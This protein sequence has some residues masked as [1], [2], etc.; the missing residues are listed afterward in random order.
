MSNSIDS[1]SH[2][3]SLMKL[4]KNYQHIFDV[5]YQLETENE[6]E[7]CNLLKDIKVILLD[8][9]IISPSD[10][11]N[12]ICKIFPYNIRHFKSYWLLFKRFYE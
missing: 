11:V 8:T 7:I 10:M 6:E 5:L 2:Y 3:D 4:F 1:H 9:N 12:I